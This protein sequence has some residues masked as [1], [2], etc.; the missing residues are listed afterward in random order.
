[1]I[2]GIAAAIIIAVAIGIHFR[3]SEIEKTEIESGTEANEKESASEIV[4]EISNS[5]QN[6]PESE[7]DETGEQSN[8]SYVKMIDGIQVVTIH[9]KEFKF[10][11]SEINI[12]PGRTKFVMINDG[13]SEHELV[14]YEESKKE[15]VDKAEIAEDEDTIAKNILFEIEEVQAGKTGESGIFDLSSGSYVI[16][17]HVPGH[18]ES[19]MKGTLK[20]S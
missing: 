9:A 1:M 3:L 5:L 7:E 12:G 14:A 18:Y 11:P 6:K 15:I 19:G 13:V 16:G 8:E 4:K 17:C 10:S 20:I 2:A